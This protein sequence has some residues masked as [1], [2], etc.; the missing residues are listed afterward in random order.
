MAAEPGGQQV[1][2][3]GRVSRRALLTGGTAVALGGLGYGFRE[4]LRGLWYRV[5]GNAVPRTEGEVD[6]AEAE[7][8]AASEANWRLASRPHDF[9]IDRVVV[10]VIQGSHATALKVFQD[11]GHRAAT[12]YV[13]RTSDGRVTQM[14]RELDVAYHAGNRAYNER[15]VGIEHEGFVDR[16]G[17]FTDA[18]YRASARLTADICDRYSLPRDR[19]HIVGHNEVPGA[20][21]TDPGP[22]WDW[23]R[24]LRMVRDA[25]P[26]PQPSGG[27]ATPS[28]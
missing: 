21:H 4:D 8:L 25:R 5:P 23:E 12:H 9:T 11:P 14:V 6:F 19:T 13:V 24:Y 22:H 27:G 17:D 3:R 2:R 20:D 10:H 1:E 26:V 15:S 28:G 7:W 18:M 16:P